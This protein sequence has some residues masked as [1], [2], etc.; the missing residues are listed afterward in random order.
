MEA[1]PAR[2]SAKDPSCEREVRCFYA[3]TGAHPV[4]V[5]HVPSPRAAT[6]RAPVVMV[7]GGGH[8]GTC[9]LATPD[10]RP[11]WAV[12][13]AAAGRDVFVPDWPGHGR[14]PQPADFPRLGTAD[15]AT[16]LLALV[17]QIG[18]AVLLVH[19][20]SGP[21]AWWMA[22]RRPD[23]VRAVIGIAPGPPA[24]LLRDLPDDPVSILA[25]RDDASAGHPVY[26]DE[27]MPVRLTAEFAAAYWANAPRFPQG[28]FENYC[29]SFAP[30][31]ARILNER[32]NIAGR[33]LRIGDPKRLRSTPIMIV[34]GD[35]DPR[36]PREAD[37]A[38]AGYLGA[39]F[40]WL[41]DRGI[42]GNG[43]MMMIENNSDDL[44]AMI[45]AWL[46]A[47]KC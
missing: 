3:G 21:M 46:D 5:D 34:T 39:E 26:S 30:E 8:T 29:R 31:S 28:A 41:P 19:S 13:F 11:G 37:A 18:P 14:S 7:H 17:E 24:N 22:E 40:V 43:H 20:A 2:R 23:L 4:Y 10:G 36:H 32:F 42:E 25:L 1:T 33:G 27:T 12:R 6:G 38:T 15:V 9:Y 45:L 44:A 35:R 16:S 47:V